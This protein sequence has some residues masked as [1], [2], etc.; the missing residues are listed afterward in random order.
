M[1]DYAT[2]FPYDPESGKDEASI[3]ELLSEMAKTMTKMNEVIENQ[4][5]NMVFIKESLS[6]IKN[7]QVNI[8]YIKQIG[9]KSYWFVNGKNTYKM[10]DNGPYSDSYIEDQIEKWEN[11]SDIFE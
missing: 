3:T 9:D 1:S 11:N 7:N 6:Q 8:P 2:S 4:N 10:V 5:Q